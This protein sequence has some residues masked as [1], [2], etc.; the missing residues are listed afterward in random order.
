PGWGRCYVKLTNELSYAEWMRG[1]KAGRSFITTGP[2]L[3][4]SADGREPGDTLRLDVPRK[5]R[6]R[7][8]A[9][10]QFPMKSLELIFNGVVVPT[11]AATNKTG[12]LVLDQEIQLDR[13]GW[14]AVRCSSANVSFP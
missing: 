1:Q 6:A 9:S 12:E 11:S 5:V 4:W 14:L 10:S 7:A 8:R 13:A 2:M 3:E